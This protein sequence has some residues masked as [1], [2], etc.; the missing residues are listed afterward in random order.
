MARGNASERGYDW[1]WQKYRIGF[2][3][4]NPLCVRCMRDQL[5]TP[6]T[7]VDH[8]TPHR[9]NEEL[10][11]NQTNHQALCKR[12]HDRKTATEDGGAP[13][14]ATSRGGG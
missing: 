12:C 10:F 7:I 2:L 3:K 5:V 9:G 4:N 6:A 14:A 13:R 1:R 8:I 11:W